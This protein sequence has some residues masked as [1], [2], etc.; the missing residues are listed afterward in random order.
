MTKLSTFPDFIVFLYVHLSQADNQYDPAEMAAIK[1][2]M[3]SL[4]PAG[5]DLEKK[6][7][8]TI[9]EYNALDKAQLPALLETSARQLGA[10]HDAD[11]EAI[12]ATMQE[13][14]R[15]DGQVA[16]AETKALEALTQLIALS[17]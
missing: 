16:P 3:A 4:Y 10:G 6:L 5:T 11:H 14:I 7:Y 1:N 13:I 9:R 12:L 15:A 17:R 8:T 2:K